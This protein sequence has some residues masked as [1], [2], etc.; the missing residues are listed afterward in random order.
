ML[1]LVRLGL[2][3]GFLFSQGSK[4]AFFQGDWELL[5]E[6]AKK[7]RRPIF[8][9]FYT[10][11]CGPCKMLERYTFSDTSVAVYVQANYLAYR[12]DCERGKGPM[13]A[14]TFRVK[15]Y[16]TIVFL[17]PEG[18]EVG[19]QVGFVDAATFLALLRRYR[20]GTDFAGPGSDLPKTH[21][22]R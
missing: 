22:H 3:S 20:E 4:V 19:R 5:L 1:G 13:L 9:D 2:L 6:E 11:W 8:V 21:S 18:R 14:N 10:T 7:Q 12:V 15:A 17:S 16:P